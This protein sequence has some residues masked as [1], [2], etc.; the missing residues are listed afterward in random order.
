MRIAIVGKPNAGKSKVG[1]P[2][3]F[4]RTPH[5]L[6]EQ[7][8]TTIQALESELSY[9]GHRFV[10]VDTAGVRRK[11]SIDSDLEQ[12]AVGQAFT[13][14]D[15]AEIAVAFSIHALEG[16]SDQDQILRR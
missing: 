12:M 3:A 13:A 11:R 6:S 14:I 2:L 1:E 16:V 9:A 15:N 5:R 4:G 8:G 7:P 10:L